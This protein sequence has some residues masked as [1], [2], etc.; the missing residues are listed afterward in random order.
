MSFEHYP[1]NCVSKWNELYREPEL[2][3][4]ILEVWR[5]DGVPADVPLMMTE[6]NLS[7]SSGGIFPDI[8]GA[9][10]L[11]DFEGSFLTAGG[12]ASS[13]STPVA[14]AST[15]FKSIKTSGLGD[16]SPSISQR[17]SSHASGH[18]PSISR[19]GSSVL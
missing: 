12:A 18:N 8:M 15:L 5:N 17:S 14:A 4:H 3:T 11:A 1:F 10:W 6:G 7:G 9:L 19:I 13:S 2:I 16:I